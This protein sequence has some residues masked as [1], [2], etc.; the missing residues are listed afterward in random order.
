M[1]QSRILIYMPT[2]EPES[3]NYK[4]IQPVVIF[5]YLTNHKVKA[6]PFPNGPWPIRKD[7]QLYVFMVCANDDESCYKPQTPSHT[8]IFLKCL[9]A[10]SA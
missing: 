5:K 9:E 7:V 3:Q 10:K 1:S 2:R 6:P 8:F 4:Y